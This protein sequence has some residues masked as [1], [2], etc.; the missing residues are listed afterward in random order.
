[1]ARRDW[2]LLQLANFNLHAAGELPAACVN[3]HMISPLHARP[4]ACRHM[5]TGKRPAADVSRSPVQLVLN[6]RKYIPPQIR[7]ATLSG[8]S[9]ICRHHASAISARITGRELTSANKTEHARSFTA[10]ANTTRLCAVELLNVTQDADV[11]ALHEVDCHTLQ[12]RKR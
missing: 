8:I 12:R 6:P 7:S 11:I 10:G 9:S 1:M 3:T 4:E 5:V 2:L